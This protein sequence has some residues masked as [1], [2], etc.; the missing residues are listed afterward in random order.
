MKIAKEATINGQV[1]TYDELKAAMEAH[2]IKADKFVDR[3]PANLPAKGEFIRFEP[4]GEGDFAHYRMVAKDEKGNEHNISISRLQAYGLE[5]KKDTDVLT[6]GNIAKSQKGNFYISGV[7]INP[8]IPSDPAKCALSLVGQ[9]FTAK[10]LTLFA[11]PFGQKFE[12]K[13]QAIENASVSAAFKV[14][15]VE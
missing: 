13:E 15:F 5:K 8:E 10:K 12:S 3:E 7:T 2:G 4:A 9:K 1:V 6:L 11:L 14:A